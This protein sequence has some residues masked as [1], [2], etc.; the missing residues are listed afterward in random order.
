VLIPLE[1]GSPEAL[2]FDQNGRLVITDY[3]GGRLRVLDAPGDD[4]WT[5]YSGLSGPGGL[6]LLPDGSLLGATGITLLSTLAPTVAIGAL[7]RYNMT[8]GE[9]TT[10]ATGLSQGNGLV[11]VPSDGTMFASD[12]SANSLDKIYPNGTTVTGWYRGSSTN[13]MAVTKDSKTLYSSLSFGKTQILSW[14]LES[15]SNVPTSYWQAPEDLA[16]AVIDDLDIDPEGRLYATIWGAGEVW[17]ID[18]NGTACALSKG[19]PFSAG[20]SLGPLFSDAGTSYSTNNSAFASDSVYFTTHLGEVA[21]IPH[22]VPT[23]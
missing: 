5:F 16:W 22:G 23:E 15:E 6:T 14:D 7:Y 2:A 1:S 4:P 17:R 8:T 19:R 12:D 11:R 13:G 9:Q 3:L 21:E 20:I 18:T 10:Y